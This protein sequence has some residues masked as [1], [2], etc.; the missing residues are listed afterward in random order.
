MADL[1]LL[2]RFSDQGLPV[3]LANVDEFKGSQALAAAGLIKLT[4]PAVKAGRGTFGQQ[5]APLVVAIT[6]AGK[7]ALAA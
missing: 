6:P 4:L 3:R 7:R 2:R 5:Q 1:A